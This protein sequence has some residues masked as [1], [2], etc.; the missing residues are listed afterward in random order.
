MNNVYIG[1]RYVPAFAN[2]TQWSA[3][4]SYEPLTIVTNN[5]NSYTSK[6][7]VPAGTQLTDT[8]YWAMTGNFNAQLNSIYNQLINIKKDPFQSKYIVIGDSFAN[9]QNSWVTQLRSL[10]GVSAADF[11][12]SANPGT[13]FHS[14]G[15]LNALN[16]LINTISNPQSF[17]YIIVQGGAN[18]NHPSTYQ[19]ANEIVQFAQRSKSV[20]INA[21]IIVVY[22]A[23][24]YQKNVYETDG[25]LR[26]NT[27][28]QYIL[29]SAMSGIKCLPDAYT[30][31]TDLA[32]MLGTDGVHPTSDG[33]T[34]LAN[35]IFFNL[36]GI[37][38][39]TIKKQFY[40]RLT[41]NDETTNGT[42]TLTYIAQTTNNHL[43]LNTSLSN[44]GVEIITTTKPT[45]GARAVILSYEKMPVL[46]LFDYTSFKMPCVINDQ[47]TTIW[48]GWNHAYGL[49]ITATENLTTA[50]SYSVK[51]TN[52]FDLPCM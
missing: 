37:E 20:F 14:G 15:Y 24:N 8:N 7:F 12:V 11:I 33:N 25:Q 22:T 4:M 30:V 10:L 1:N 3:S 5:G 29:G 39:S 2:P 6:Q 13:G 43:W 34:E 9:Q 26:L 27:R 41:I 51:S 28:Y 23:T 31:F 48:I 32:Y 49:Y 16:T 19:V 38:V 40:R 44:T 18:D 35:Y 50:D 17:D 46:P 47:I 45:I 21:M 52:M 42:A 36:T